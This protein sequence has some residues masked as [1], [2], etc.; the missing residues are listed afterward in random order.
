[1]SQITD[2]TIRELAGA[3]RAGEV[4][5]VEATQATLDRIAAVDPQVQSYISLT[6][7]LALE[8]AKAADATLAENK[9]AHP[10]TGVPL[11]I[12]D[13]LAVEGSNTTAGSKILEGFQPPYDST[14]VRN[15]RDAGAVFVGKTN[16]DEFG[17]GSS[18]ENSAYQTTRNPWD[19]ERVPGGSSG[20]SAAAV[21]AR[22][23]QGALGTD[24]GGSIRQPA[25]LCGITGFK[26]SYGRVS[27]YGA[28]AYASSLDQIGPFTRTVDDAALMFSTI[29]GQDP[30]DATTIGYDVPDFTKPM[31]AMDSL[32]GVRVG[33]PKEYFID[34]MASDVEDTV[35]AAIAEMESMGAELVEIS[36]PHTDYNMPAYYILATAE[37]SSNLARY[38]SIRF[39]LREHTGDLNSQ[40]TDSRG[41]GFGQEVKRRIMLGTYALSTGYYDAY[42]LKAQKVRTLIK[43]DFDNAFQNVDVIATPVSPTTAFKIGEK[44]D[45]PIAMYL[46]DVFTLAVNMSGICGI[47]LPCGQDSSNLPVGLQLMGPAFGEERLL[48]VAHTY[49]TATDW[50]KAVAQI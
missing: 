14:A 10:L 27:R 24:T 6:A 22:L 41:A 28:I 9:D 18:T 1:M 16:T 23:C 39:G 7:E 26:P 4:S 15:L 33:V 43:Q 38:D 17:M 21:A 30:L 11:G 25:S 29:A 36:L 34:G 48:N 32:K 13:L 12:K 44:S 42:Y 47:S 45:D 20:G 40:Y 49:Q 19:L 5:S 37:A 3:L 31:Q 35:R 46:A 50:H 8:Q 2:L